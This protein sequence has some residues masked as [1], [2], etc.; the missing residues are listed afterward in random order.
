MGAVT[1]AAAAHLLAAR[2]V[3]DVDEGLARTEDGRAWCAE[4][5]YTV[6][7]ATEDAL[8]RVLYAVLG[9]IG[10]YLNRPEVSLSL[11]EWFVAAANA[12]RIP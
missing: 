11:G 9:V 2:P 5:P 8:G 3:E 12:E 4:Q 1:T 10:R 6:P 7:P